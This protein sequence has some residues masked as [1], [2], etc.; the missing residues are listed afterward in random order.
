M[1]AIHDPE[2]SESLR[3]LH[4]SRIAL[5]APAY[6]G[7]YQIVMRRRI[8]TALF[9]FILFAGSSFANQERLAFI[10]YYAWYG[11]EESD[12]QWIHWQDY[13]HQPPQDLSS[14][15]YP[16]LGAYSSRNLAT[17]DQHMRW[18]AGANL[19]VLIYSWW[20]RD[21][22][23]N[24][25]AKSVLDA[26]ADYNLKVAFMIEPYEG[27]TP[28]GVLSDIE[29][30]HEQYGNHPA[31]FRFARKTAYGASS[32]RRAFI[33]LYQPD[34]S[35]DEL[36]RLSDSVHE[37]L[38]DSILLLQST[39]ASLIDRTHADG[40][41][42]YEAVQPIMDL[43]PGITESVRSEDGIFIPCVSPGFN[44]N[45]T[46]RNRSSLYRPRAHGKTYDKWW[47]RTLVAEPE[48]VAILTFNEWHEGTQI[49]P[50]IRN[51][52]F[53]NR[54]LSYEHAYKKRGKAAQESYLRRTARWI[55]LFQ[56]LP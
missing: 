41:F 40:I 2:G 15:Y 12:S 43:Y 25:A 55:D 19:N 56:Q 13:G 36:R 10:Y 39:D 3:G 11:N 14:A 28:A 21:D 44:V 1:P 53:G 18:I 6:D 33:F 27:R 5:T 26:A 16:K 50:A 30:I 17:I 37:S 22:P 42:A 20:G 4:S 51:K 8:V 34:F 52:K 49:E 48:F 31:F 32:A 45:R 38:C 9:C 24:A 54:Y 47:E 23:A 7:Y 46:F 29:Y 35:E